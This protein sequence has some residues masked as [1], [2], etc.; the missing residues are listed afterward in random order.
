LTR[1]NTAQLAAT[2]SAMVATLAILKPRARTSDRA[3]YENWFIAVSAIHIFVPVYMMCALGV[4]GNMIH[5]DVGLGRAEMPV[6]RGV[7]N[8]I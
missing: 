8:G 6:V 1:P 7:A 5:G 3:E 4:P 2:A